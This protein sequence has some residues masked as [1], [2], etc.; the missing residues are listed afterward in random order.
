M[1]GDR[2]LFGRVPRDA[3]GNADGRD[4]DR[5]KHLERAPPAPA[6]GRDIEV[7]IAVG[8]ADH[9]LELLRFRRRLWVRR[10]RAR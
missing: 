2:W 9:G 1:I 5:R 10:L 3:A 4:E 8:R 7:E 6:I